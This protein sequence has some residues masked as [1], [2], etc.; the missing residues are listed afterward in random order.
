MRC[1]R[2][3][4][5]ILGSQRIVQVLVEACRATGQRSHRIVEAIADVA[6]GAER[7]CIDQTKTARCDA[8]NA[9]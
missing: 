7:E 1:S 4:C 8:S 3:W 6:V 9:V 5:T 2:A